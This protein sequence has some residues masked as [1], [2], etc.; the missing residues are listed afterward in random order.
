MRI[1]RPRPRTGAAWLWLALPVV[2]PWLTACAALPG[3]PRAVLPVP[4]SDARPAPAA[5]AAGLRAHD[6]RGPLT[7]PRRQALI[8]R[9]G[10]EGDA[11]LLN[12]HLAA[13]AAL[14]AR[15][16]LQLIAGNQARLLIDGP[17]AFAAMEQAIA[18]ARHSVWL[19]S[20][21]IEDGALAQ[22]LAALLQRKRA[23]GVTVRVIYDAVGSFG[24]D[25]AYFEGLHAAGVAT[26]M[27]NPLNPLRRGR[28]GDI[29]ERDHRKILVVDDRV[30]FTGGINISGVYASG[31]FGRTR[32]L[33][34]E[35]AGW[36]DTQIR[37][38]GPAA[39]VLGRLVRETWQQQRCQD[40]APGG[41]ITAPL[42]AAGTDAPAPAPADNAGDD[43]LR[44]VPARPAD[45]ENPI[46]DLLLLAIDTARRSVHLTMAYFAPG[47][48]MVEALSDAARRG[49]DVQLILPSHSDFPPVLAAGRHHYDTLLDAGVRI[50]ELQSAVLHA[51]TAVI[52]G[53]VSTVGSSNMDWRSFTANQEVNAVVLGQDFGDAMTR[54]FEAD[55]QRSQE[56]TVEAWRQRPLGQRLRQW[57]A[58][59]F[60]RWW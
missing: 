54:M 17:A 23:H 55:R 5:L 33:S 19:E 22:R 15:D 47:R 27:F 20:Y 60:E 10:R 39:R 35:E 40:E 38:E 41:A 31:S 51:K 53:V 59:Q 30:A 26:C 2:L 48:E 16:G 6:A 21:I 56:I 43:V 12:R 52:D 11:S 50:H 49:V 4:G 44:I 18:S 13:M 8:E 42:A 45:G 46:H 28:Y 57:L 7:R 36:R 9:L 25:E 37:I 1:D 14:D 58:V 29:T 34:V 3:T 24:T 32:R